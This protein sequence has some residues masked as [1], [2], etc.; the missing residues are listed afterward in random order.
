MFL[1]RQSQD[2]SYLASYLQKYQQLRT[3]RR[4]EVA[5]ALYA[6]HI[7]LP[8]CAF[9]PRN[10]EGRCLIVG[11]RIVYITFII[12]E[13]CACKCADDGTMI[14]NVSF[15]EAT[16]KNKKCLKGQPSNMGMSGNSQ[17]TA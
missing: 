5:K 15:M 12:I 13:V 3:T 9:R 6:V 10:K 4:C 1:L 17:H 2:S 14:I 11:L 7:E 16:T 8:G